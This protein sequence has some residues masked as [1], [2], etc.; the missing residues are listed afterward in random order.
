MP[1]L[2]AD[3]IGRLMIALTRQSAGA[4]LA[5]D[6]QQGSL[7]ADQTGWSCPAAIVAT[8]VSATTNFGALKVG[9]LVLHIP[10]VAGSAIFYTVA[11]AGTLPAAA[12]VGDLYV[13]LRAFA[14]P[15]AII[16]TI[17]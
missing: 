12:V 5:Q 9:D 8:S 6:V 2:S 7:L 14:Q 10:A 11:T 15:A 13:A 3:T 16:Q 1:S 4:E 17:P